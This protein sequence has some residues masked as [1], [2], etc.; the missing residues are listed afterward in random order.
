MTTFNTNTDI[1][2]RTDHT[3]T[4]LRAA[5]AIIWQLVN[6]VYVIF[7]PKAPNSEHV[8][9]KIARREAARRATDNLLR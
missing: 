3:S 1:Q 2:G 5:V 7:T 4:V 8:L 9:A 6:Q